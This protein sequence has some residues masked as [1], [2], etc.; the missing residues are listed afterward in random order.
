METPQISVE[1]SKIKQEA[2]MKISSSL[3]K[4]LTQPREYAVG[5][6]AELSKQLENSRTPKRKAKVAERLQQWKEFFEAYQARELEE[7]TK[8]ENV[9]V[10]AEET[11]NETV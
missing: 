2:R 6:I 11:N 3:L 4:L 8:A 1:N 10:V 5:A 7:K 9:E